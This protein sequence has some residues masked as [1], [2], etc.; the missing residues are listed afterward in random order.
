MKKIKILRMFLLFFFCGNTALIAQKSRSDTVNEANKNRQG[1]DLIPIVWEPK[2]TEISSLNV[3][4]AQAIP[5]FRFALKVP[6]TATAPLILKK[7]KLEP[8]SSNNVNW[9]NTLAQLYVE[10][11]HNKMATLSKINSKS[12][13]I[14]FQ[15]TCRIAP[16]QQASFLILGYIKKGKIA[17]NQHLQLRINKKHKGW[18]VDSLGSNLSAAFS[19]EQESPL[20]T[21]KVEATQIAFT[22]QPDFVDYRQPFGVSVSVTDKYNNIDIDSNKSITLDVGNGS[23]FIQ[24]K[25]GLTQ[26]TTKGIASWNDLIYSNADYFQLQATAPNFAVAMS[27]PI[28]AIDQSSRIK[29]YPISNKK[30]PAT[31]I[32]PQKAFPVFRFTITD[33]GEHDTLSTSITTLKFLKQNRANAFLWDKHI[34]GA[35]ITYQGEIIASTTNVHQN[36]IRFYSSK[37]LL[38]VP[39]NSSRMFDMNIYLRQNQTPDNATF[40]TELSTKST[41][42]KTM[43]NSSKIAPTATNL[44]SAVS[45]I[46]VLANRIGFIQ[47]PFCLNK[48]VFK[49]KIAAMDSLNNIDIDCSETFRLK[50]IK[51]KGSLSGANKTFRLKKGTLAISSLQ[52][53]GKDQFQLMTQSQQLS[54]TC[55]I[56]GDQAQTVYTDDFENK[57]FSNFMGTA[58]WRISNYQP[59]VGKQSVKH[60]VIAKSGSS[61][62][63]KQV[64]HIDL[65]SGVTQW[66]WLIKTGNWKPSL[67]NYVV[68][69][70]FVDNATTHKAKQQYVVG[71]RF[72]STDNRLSLWSTTTKKALR[73][74]TSS[75]QWKKNETVALK[76][77][78]SP[79]GIWQL[80]YNRLGK[81]ENWQLAGECFA[82]IV[83]S[84]TTWF[85]TLQYHYR[86]AE[87]AGELWF[88]NL[89][90][91]HCN[92]APFI[93]SYQWIDNNAMVI[94]FSEKIKALRPSDVQI[95]INNDVL[96]NF[97][98]EQKTNSNQIKIRRQQAF[99]SGRYHIDIQQIKDIDGAT[100]PKDSLVFDYYTPANSGDVV[101]NE[102]LF[103]PLHGGSDYVEIYNLS[104]NIIDVSSICLGKRNKQMRIDDTVR[105]SNKKLLLHPDSYMVFSADT[106]NIKANYF[107]IDESVCYSAKIPNYRNKEDRVVL[108][109]GDYII[110]ELSYNEKMH[111]ELL[112]DTKGVALERVSPQERTNATGNWQS[113]SQ[114][115][116]FGTPGLKNSVYAQSKPTTQ[117]IELENR[118]FTPN[119]DGVTDRLYI[120]FNLPESGY[121]VNISIF[122]STGVE[123][124]KLASNYY[125]GIHNKLIWDGLDAKK[126]PLPAGIYIIYAELFHPSGKKKVFKK[127]AVIAGKFY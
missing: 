88:D 6:N 24:S 96:S 106:A 31:A 33:K 1:T 40:Q 35:T 67:G 97:D 64:K 117:I 116:G 63:T 80:Y 48:P 125:L 16:K 28:G 72:A 120:H 87:N 38:S 18:E 21:L 55:T 66:Q 69:C 61:F 13:Y 112:T 57:S 9:N 74:I 95:L 71:F 4:K 44:I 59:I 127:T 11:N 90:I 98:I 123:I 86:N 36:Y 73:F 10:C 23:G 29:Q 121:V 113:A 92:T 109:R 79:K 99:P 8:T 34:A 56:F 60:N 19:F 50:L 77:I 107:T 93:Q 3:T 32:T 65:S 46:S 68:F 43:T 49:V 30:I 91:T 52:Y 7:I 37:G 85:S 119:G 2:N 111:F 14:T 75:F 27:H 126:R 62:L 82:P 122:S 70:P 22:K 15:N 39:N 124:R 45:Q 25:T 94:Q 104:S 42:L 102:I 108:C 101:I 47:A 41:D 17:D 105:L 58:H 54:D 20:W 76:V 81:T 26:T 115:V 110:D 78:Y 51:G 5:L 114:N 100:N 12:I 118:L 83:N 103:H 84:A 89:S 53:R